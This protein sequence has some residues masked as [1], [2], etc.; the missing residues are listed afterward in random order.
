MGEFGDISEQDINGKNSSAEQKAQ[1]PT[2]SSPQPV[3]DNIQS[4]LQSGDSTK[5]PQQDQSPT[6]TYKDHLKE[7]HAQFQAS[8]E[9]INSEIARATH[10]TPAAK[11]RIIA[12]QNSEVYD[13][14]TEDGQDV[15]LRIARND[16]PRFE[17]ERWALGEAAKAGVSVPDVLLTDTVP[18]D[19]QELGLC[20][21]K[22]LQGIPLG[23]RE[24]LTEAEK[25]D[26]IAKAGEQLAKIHSVETTGFGDLDRHGMGRYT[27]WDGYISSIL[28]QAEPLMIAAREGGYSEDSV[29]KALEIIER[30]RPLFRD[31]PSHLLHGD[32][33]PKHILTENDEI[34]GVIDFENC[35]GGDPIYDF[36]NWDFWY[37]ESIPLDWLKEGYSNKEVIDDPNFTRKLDLYKLHFGLDV[38][39]YFHETGN[40]YG[41]EHSAQQIDHVLENFTP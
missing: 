27:T 33:G 37:G 4:Q 11:T 5:P 21:Q 20:V 7:I 13:I 2:T 6:T 19:G 3:V 12:G 18:I 24:E 22:K 34:T 23:D 41:F 28:S 31:V 10:S 9:V 30:D 29:K 35:K 15:I 39:K 25:K 32:F 14:H 1:T 17:E 16:Y 26:L 38:L 8:D 36:A 40:P